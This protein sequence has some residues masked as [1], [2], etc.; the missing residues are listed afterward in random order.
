MEL[1]SASLLPPPPIP[2]SGAPYAP[3]SLALVAG[4]SSAAQDLLGSGAVDGV[5][6]LLP[7]T[8]PNNIHLRFSGDVALP[9]AAGTDFGIPPYVFTGTGHLC[10]RVTPRLRYARFFCAAAVTLQY[11]LS[12]GW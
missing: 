10:F 3:V 11:Y 6:V 5:L 7:F 1:Y 2:G 9:A 4:V 8:A 12:R